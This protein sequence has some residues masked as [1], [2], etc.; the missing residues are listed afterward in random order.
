MKTFVT[1]V[2]TLL[3]VGSACAA[4]NQTETAED[5]TDFQINTKE[6][7]SYDV[8]N[9]LD[10]NALVNR[11]DITG[12]IY[13]ISSSI[14]SQKGQ[15]PHTDKVISSIPPQGIVITKPGTYTFSGDLTWSPNSVPCAAITIIAD[16]VVLDMG[17]FNLTAMVQNNNE[18]HAGIYIQN[19]SAVTIRNGTLVNMSLYGIYAVH[20]SSLRIKNVTVSGISLSNLDIRNLCPSGILIDNAHKVHITDCTVQNLQVTSD[21]SAGIQLLH[22]TKG[23]VSGCRV[24]NLVNSDG[25]VQGYSYLQSNNITT[26]NCRADNFQ[27][28]FNGNIHTTGHTVL[29]FIPIFCS[30]LKYENCSATN[31]IGCC[32]D[33]HGM[34]VFLDAKVAVTNFMANTVIDGVAQ[35]NSGAKATGLEVYG[36]DVSIR[37]CSVENIIAINPQD[38]Q[39]T[40]FSAW[41]AR[42]SFTN[43]KA[44]N[45]VVCDENGDEDPAL[46]YGTGFGWAPDPRHPFSD[47][48]AYRVAYNHCSARDCQVGFDT[49]FHVN[50]TWTNVDCEHCDINILVE[51]DGQRTLSCNPCSECDPPIDIVIKNIAGGNTYPPL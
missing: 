28:H 16:K 20:V 19:A 12:A 46:G 47:I 45:V 14:R 9:K 24:R 10:K 2:T 34:S 1:V 40:G 35:S 4:E 49:W 39:S 17:N 36:L 26:S 50:S 11:Y 7:I 3:L 5:S 27:S 30:N 51:P 38:K 8:F 13:D 15:R 23:V 43:C 32:D 41:G 44:G 42:I 18:F 48:G 29:G 25:S 33:S 6:D 22:T 31:M 21:S 37:N